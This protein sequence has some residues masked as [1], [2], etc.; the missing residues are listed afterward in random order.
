MD[1]KWW[2]L[3]E[4]LLYGWG[5]ELC[6]WWNRKFS[7]KV[8]FFPK[9]GKK[10]P[11]RAKFWFSSYELK[12]CWS[13]KLQDS[14][15]CNISRKKW[16]MRVTC[17]MQINM[18]VFYMLILLFWVYAARHAQ[19]TQNRSFHIFAIFTE[20]HGGWKSLP[21]DKA[22]KKG[23]SITLGDTRIQNNK[24]AISLQYIKENRKNEVDFLPTDKHQR[25][26]QIN[27][28]ILGVC[29]YASHVQVTQNNNVSISLQ[30]LKKEVSDEVNVFHFLS[31]MIIMKGPYK[32]I[33]WFLM[34]ALRHPKSSQNSKFVMSLQ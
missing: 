10:G 6:C 23:G 8:Y 15:K 31:F 17:G 2:G 19:S 18:V 24:F 29:C 3:Q 16:M 11:Y 22:R 26:L 13:I 21:A 1:I 9:L 14:L 25:F 5:E 27:T 33:L 12:C 30:Y 28:I 32:L 7:G 20:K 34:G 4:F